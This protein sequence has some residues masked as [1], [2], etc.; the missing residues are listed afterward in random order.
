MRQQETDTGWFDR[1]WEQLLGAKSL[2]SAHKMSVSWLCEWIDEALAAEGK[3]ATRIEDYTAYCSSM[4][5]CAEPWRDEDDELLVWCWESAAELIELYDSGRQ[6]SDA[7]F[8]EAFCEDIDDDPE[9]K[10][11]VAYA[12]HLIRSVMAYIYGWFKLN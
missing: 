9:I 10:D 12:H 6:M 3:R 8:V 7:E 5:E 11:K 4:T 2:K 1:V